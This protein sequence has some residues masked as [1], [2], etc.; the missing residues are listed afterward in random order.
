LI[1]SIEELA[2]DPQRGDAADAGLPRGLGATAQRLL[3]R[4][5]GDRGGQPV[6]VEPGRLRARGE[7]P[8]IGEIPAVG[9][10]RGKSGLDKRVEA[11]TLL[12][13][14]SARATARYA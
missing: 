6:A 5:V 8:E 7:Q 3:D 1:V 9:E 2:A 14:E 11:T 12:R 10:L 13:P 4:V